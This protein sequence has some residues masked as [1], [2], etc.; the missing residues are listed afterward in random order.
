MLE[1][2]I[3]SKIHTT[4]RNGDGL[5]NKDENKNQDSIENE[6]HRKMKDNRE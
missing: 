3:T 6:G 5:K 4:C 2:K 1:I